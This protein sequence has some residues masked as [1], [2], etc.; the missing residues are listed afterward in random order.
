MKELE[1]QRLLSCSGHLVRKVQRHDFKWAPTSKT[2][3]LPGLLTSGTFTATQVAGPEVLQWL[4]TISVASAWF[5]SLCFPGSRCYIL[6]LCRNSTVNYSPWKLDNAPDASNVHRKQWQRVESG[7]A[8][9]AHSL[10]YLHP[11]LYTYGLDPSALPALQTCEGIM[12]QMLSPTFPMVSIILNSCLVSAGFGR[13]GCENTEPLAHVWKN[14]YR[15][16]S[17]I[18][19]WSSCCVWALCWAERKTEEYKI[20]PQ[21]TLSWGRA[22]GG[23]TGGQ[24]ESLNPV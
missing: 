8:M 23:E 6:T 15:R 13:S 3:P 24:N 20:F 10:T 9:P 7:C 4:C 21:G 22:G 5:F 17:P 12:G 1:A 14:V 2:M 19:P 16:C 11:S 18:T